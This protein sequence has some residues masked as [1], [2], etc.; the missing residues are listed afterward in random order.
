MGRVK[1]QNIVPVSDIYQYLIDKGVPDSHVKGMLANIKAESGFNAAITE[2]GKNGGGGLGLF[3]HTGPRRVALERHIG[4]DISDWKSQIDYALSESSTKDYLKQDFSTPQEAS[5]WF[6]TKWERPADAHNQ[7]IKRQKFLDTFTPGQVS[8]AYTGKN[9]NSPDVMTRQQC[10]NPFDYSIAGNSPQNITKEQIE[11]ELEKEKIKKE[12]LLQ[13][14]A[15]QKLENER[16]LKAGLLENL[17]AS[18][19]TQFTPMETTAATQQ[20]IQ[21][22]VAPVQFAPIQTGLPG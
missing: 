6:T 2:I 1:N 18:V 3:Q 19:N 5:Y 15:T 16:E 9:G 4:G 20:F 8:E 14:E 11:K 10:V 17:S 22:P 13:T 21:Q 7:A 12:E